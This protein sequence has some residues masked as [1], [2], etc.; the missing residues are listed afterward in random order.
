MFKRKR[1][2]KKGEGRKGLT[3]GGGGCGHSALAKAS[4]LREGANKNKISH[5]AKD[6]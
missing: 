2:E 5:T 6:L 3:I 1:E 4:E